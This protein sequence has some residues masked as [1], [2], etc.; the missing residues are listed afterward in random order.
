M[1]QKSLKWDKQ[2]RL[3][4]SVSF[5]LNVFQPRK[6]IRFLLL[7]SQT[8]HFDEVVCVFNLKSGT[9]D[10]E[11]VHNPVFEEIIRPKSGLVFYKTTRAFIPYFKFKV[12]R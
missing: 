5:L 2:S 1:A 3:A 10:P 12:L 9:R 8:G 6:L 4:G 7:L 11:G